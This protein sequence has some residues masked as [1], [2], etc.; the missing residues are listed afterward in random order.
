MFLALLQLADSLFLSPPG[1]GEEALFQVRRRETGGC[2]NHFRGIPLWPPGVRSTSEK[3]L[4]P[5]GTGDPL[6]VHWYSGRWAG[7]RYLV[8]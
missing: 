1:F 6:V 2:A 7:E 8:V 3:V 5:G 4:E